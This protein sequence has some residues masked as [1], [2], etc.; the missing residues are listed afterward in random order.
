[1]SEACKSFSLL[2]L[3]FSPASML[4][5]FPSGPINACISSPPIDIPISAPASTTSS[6]PTTGFLPSVYTTLLGEVWPLI[7][8]ASC[9]LGVWP[10]G[11]FSAQAI[12]LRVSRAAGLICFSSLNSALTASAFSWGGVAASV[13]CGTCCSGAFWTWPAVGVSEP[14]RSPD[15]PSGPHPAATIGDAAPAATADITPSLASQSL[16][17][18]KNDGFLEGLW[19][20]LTFPVPLQIVVDVERN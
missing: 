9:T 18:F 19:L 11:K 12:S 2:A 17:G 14:L 1:M 3:P 8:F 20:R 16:C 15:F 5:I 13:L 7:L 10:S 6:G 4:A